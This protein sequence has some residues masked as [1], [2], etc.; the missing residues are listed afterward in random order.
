[1]NEGFLK[2]A[3]NSLD[4]PVNT[5]P[6]GIF[7]VYAVSGNAEEIHK[8]IR[9][10]ISGIRLSI[11][12]MGI[13]LAK[14]KANHLYLDLGC[15]TMGRYI[16]RLCDETKMDRSSIFNWLCIGESYL[17]YKNDL[18]TVGFNDGDGPT[19]LPYLERALKKNQKRE[20]FS[21][22]K[23][24]SVREF[25]M[26]SKGVAAQGAVA[27]PA[28]AGRVLIVRSWKTRIGGRPVITIRALTNNQGED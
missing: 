4:K 3:C 24:M 11:L 12:A 14:M 17:K 9:D 7:P 22:I 1:M 8:G 21:N 19:K 25:E 5:I 23:R 28:A 26:F 2:S 18:E 6:G 13:G 15:D 20:V 16:Q 10:T 27:K